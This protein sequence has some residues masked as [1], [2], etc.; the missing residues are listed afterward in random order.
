MG[1]VRYESLI[2]EFP[3]VAEKLFEICEEDAKER[4]TNYKRLAEG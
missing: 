1:Q 2:T 4:L 3:D